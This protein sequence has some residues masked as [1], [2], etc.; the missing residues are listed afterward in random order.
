MI[1]IAKLCNHVVNH[2]SYY[3]MIRIAKLCNHVVNHDS[4]YHMICILIMDQQG[5]VTIGRPV[6]GRGSHV[7]VLGQSQAFL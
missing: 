7:T 3:H 4:Y 2:D 6:I 1:R 5:R